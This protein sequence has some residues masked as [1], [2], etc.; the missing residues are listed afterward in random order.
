MS[1]ETIKNVVYWNDLP[2]DADGI[3][4]MKVHAD[5]TT[6]DKHV[7]FFDTPEP[8]NLLENAGTE[9]KQGYKAACDEIAKRVARYFNDGNG[10]PTG[11][12][13]HQIKDI[14]AN[15]KQGKGRG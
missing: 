7:K 5:G 8:E 1:E 6:S 2:Q 13:E 3:V 15:V 10:S 11:I 14:I 4:M 12:S 9:Y